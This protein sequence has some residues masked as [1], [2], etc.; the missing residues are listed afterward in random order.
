MRQPDAIVDEVRAAREAIAM[1]FDYDIAKIA[2]AVRA[3]EARSGRTV[4]NLPPRKATPARNPPQHR[5]T[6]A[7]PQHAVDGAA[8]RG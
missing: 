8:R 7:E 6:A 1:E 4:V 5:E 2:E 3:R